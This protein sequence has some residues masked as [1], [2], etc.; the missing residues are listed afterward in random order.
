MKNNAFITGFKCFK[1]IW[2]EN[3]EAEKCSGEKM[4]QWVFG[5]MIPHGKVIRVG[6]ITGTV[7]EDSEALNVPK[8]KTSYPLTD[9]WQVSTMPPTL[10][11]SDLDSDSRA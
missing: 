1:I 9:S 2:V 4:K 5:R 11:M 6:E 10:S 8:D 3:D 7:T